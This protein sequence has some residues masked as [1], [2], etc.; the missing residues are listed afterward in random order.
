MIRVAVVGYGFIGSVHVA[1]LK[2]IPD[3]RVVA[4]VDS[5]PEKFKSATKGN[6][7]VGAQGDELQGIELYTSLDEMLAKT[8][9]DCV[10]ICL[11][12]NLHRLVTEQVMQA[13]KHVICEKPMALTLEDCDAMIEASQK[14]DRQLF[15]A[16]CIRFW[17]EYEA[18]KKMVDSGE[19]GAPISFL[20]RRVGPSPFWAGAQSWFSDPNKSGGCVFDLHVHDTDYVQYLFGRPQAVYSQGF[21]GQSGGNEA[22]MTQYQYLSGPMCFAEGSWAY[23]SGFRMTFTAIFENAQVEYDSAQ[24]PSMILYRKGAD[25]SEVVE[26][27]DRDGYYHEMAY[28][29]QCLRSGKKPEKV[30]PQSAR[31]SIEIALAEAASINSKQLEE[32]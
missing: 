7:D 29:I 17:P 8:D 32:L 25:G 12:T 2:K 9:V 30:L 27:D 18:L 15:I 22:V 13:G 28:F 23:S 1:T 4:V 6:L 10:S 31:Q 26:V 19:F 5:N 14:Y 21:T 24:S 3:A 16:Q 11:P 20:F